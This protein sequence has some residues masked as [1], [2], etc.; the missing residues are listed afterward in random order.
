[1]FIHIAQPIHEV[2]VT[3]PDPA[4]AAKLLEQFG[5]G[6]GE[7]TAALTYFTQSFHTEDAALRDMLLDIATE[8][9][10]HLEM[11]GLLIEQHTK[12]GN[13]KQ[14]DA[15]YNSTLFALRG[16]GPHL[17]DAG[18]SFWDARYVN[19]G[20]SPVRD[21]RA[22]IGAEGAALAAYEA[23]IPLSPDDGTRNALRHLATREVSHTQ[24]FMTALASMDKLDKP[25]FGDLQPDDTV[26]VY[27]NLSTGP[28]A[29]QRG[30]WNREPAFRYVENPRAAMGHSGGQTT[31][32]GAA[33][34]G[35][36]AH[37]PQR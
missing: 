19:E 26:N 29:D 22:N 20:A 25:L 2:R 7:L 28:G 1:M 5:G 14:Q 15:A 34:Q 31:G 9:F 6:P 8:E 36:G 33:Q 27:Y 30:P 21:L 24:M 17:L 13:Q 32:P 35:S 23:L 12:R 37:N 3:Q 16:P 10:G 18:G 11:V 4:F